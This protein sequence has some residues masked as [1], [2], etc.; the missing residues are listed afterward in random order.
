MSAHR[1]YE[2][3]RVTVARLISMLSEYPSGAEVRVGIQPSYPLQVRLNGRI[4]GTLDREDYWGDEVVWLG[5][6]SANDY[7]EGEVVNAIF[8]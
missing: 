1:D 7:L 6:G 8:R 2:G 4:T 3:M 5:T